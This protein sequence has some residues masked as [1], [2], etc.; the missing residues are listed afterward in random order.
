MVV[1]GGELPQLV[2]LVNLY[3]SDPL[4]HPYL[5][6][7]LTYDLSVSRVHALINEYGRV[8]G[9]ALIWGVGRPFKCVI[10]WGRCSQLVRRVPKSPKLIVQA[11]DAGIAEDVLNHLKAL[12]APKESLRIAPYLDMAVGEEG[13]TPYETFPKPV[14]LDP[15]NDEHV[16][17]FASI[18][19]E[20]VGREEEAMM[21]PELIRRYRPY[22]IFVG[23]R[24]ASV[25]MTYVRMPEV[26]VVGGVYTKPQY[27]GRGYA[28]AVTS[29]V[30][31]DALRAGAKAL[32]QVREDNEPA[33]RV[34]RR[35]GYEP[36]GRRYWVLLNIKPAA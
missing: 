20:S 18:R 15:R 2:S 33:V 32:L 11:P 12:G 5:L 1:G 22:A 14:M 24:I 36:I 26:W 19:V 10:L 23:R 29:A 27:R 3:L 25:A 16:R 17:E 31:R 35:L 28:K 4:H 21:A 7:D 9:Y 13:F 6:Y 34:Y 8:V 30:T